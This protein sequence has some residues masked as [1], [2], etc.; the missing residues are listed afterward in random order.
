V[1][2]VDYASLT[3]AITDFAHRADLQQNIY[4]DYFIQTAQTK[5]AR[6]IIRLNFGNGIEAME[7][8]MQPTQIAGGTLPVPSDWYAPKTLQVADGSGDVFTLIFKAAAWIYNIYPIREPEGLPAYI[9]RDVMAACAFNGSTSGNTLTVNSVTLGQIQVG[10]IFDDITGLLPAQSA[11]TGFLTGTG[12]VGT[13]STNTSSSVGAESMTGG[14]NVFIFGPYPDSAYT[15]QGTY[16][17]RGM[18][19]STANPTN[20]MVLETPE[21]LHAACMVEAGKFLKD[22]TM[23]GQWTPI[24]QDFVLGVLDDAN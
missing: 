3:Q 17:S 2:I 22:D 7:E 19:L 20:W 6:D 11:I 5:L 4:T 24:Y 16:Y 14:G 18:A 23:V 1:Q 13:Y 10:M 12:G 8:A 21:A 15:V 9:A